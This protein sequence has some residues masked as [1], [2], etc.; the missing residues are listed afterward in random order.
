[1][2][3]TG[4]QRLRIVVRAL[5]FCQDHLLVTQ[6]RDSYAFLIGGR[7]EHG[8]PLHEAVLREV[9]EETGMQGRLER[10]LYFAETFYPDHELDYHEYGWYF[11]IKLDELPCPL[12]AIIPNPDHPDLIIR[13]VPLTQ[14]PKLE[15]YPS[16]LKRYVAA[17]YET[18]FGQNPRHIVTNQHIAPPS[19]Q[20]IDIG[21]I[22]D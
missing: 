6:W 1:M 3:V 17:D 10:L 2:K 14:L 22:P 7:V 20:Q 13:W 9:Q 15:L 18:D 5:I 11:L 12:D 16:L 4:K 8:E 21:P 19:I